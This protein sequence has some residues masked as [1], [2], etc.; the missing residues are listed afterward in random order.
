MGFLVVM[1]Q[2]V[3][4]EVDKL[5][6]EVI[7]HQGVVVAGAP[8]AGAVQNLLRQAVV[9]EVVLAIIHTEDPEVEQLD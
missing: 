3:L 4:V 8:F 2:V 6:I 9:A 1:R 5:D 7:I